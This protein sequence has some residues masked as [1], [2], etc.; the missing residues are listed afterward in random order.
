MSPQG[1]IESS[2]ALRAY[3]AV[4][5]G[6]IE[7]YGSG[8]DLLPLLDD[9][10]SF[11]GPIAGHVEGAS[12]F[13]R[14]VKGFIETVREIDFIQAVATEDGAAVLYDAVLPNATVRFAEFFEFEG[15]VI[16]RV[17]ILYNASE[18]TAAGGH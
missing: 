12:R 8:E 13:A 6:G 5:L 17:S 4:L 1:I 3:Y 16:R 14:G 11:D 15:G 10:F 7:K 18:Y 2:S 9:R